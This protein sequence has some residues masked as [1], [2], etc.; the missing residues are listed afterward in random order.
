[1]I[2]YIFTF[3]LVF[4]VINGW[5]VE[6]SNHWAFKTV[7]RPIV[8][9]I[10]S[11]WPNDQIDRFVLSKLLK[12]GMQPAGRADRRTLIRRLSLDLAG[13]PPTPEQVRAFVDNSSSNAYREL[14]DQLLAS[15]RFGE[16]WARHWLDVARYADTK[17]YLAGNQARLFT[18]SYTYRD[19]VIDSFN[20]DLPYDRFLIEQLA[21]DKLDLADDNQPLAAMG[22]LTLG[23]RFLNNPHDIIDDRIDVVTRGLMALTVSCARCHD[24]K[25]DPIPAADYYSL[26]GVFASSHEPKE[27]PYISE[28]SDPIKRLSFQKELKR[29]QDN[30]N[31]YEKA[32]YERIRKQVK[33]Q[34][35]EYIWAAHSAAK[36]AAGEIDELARKSKL[37]PDVTR[38]WMNYLSERR[39]ANDLVFAAWFALAEIDKESYVAEFKGVLDKESL[40][41]VPLEILEV[42]GQALSLKDAAK[43]FGKLCFEADESQ[44]MLREVVYSN[45]SPAKLSDGDV[46]RIMEVSGKE[47]IRSR[48]RK[49]D[50]IE[51]EH[52]GAPNRAMVMID[53]PS[54]Y[55]PYVFLR[56]NPSSKG[57]SVP[58]Q[59]LSVLS[60]GKRKP[61]SNGSGRLEMA[62]AIAASDNPLTA[63]VMVNR[64]WMHLFGQGL[65]DT[66][67]DFGVRAELPSHPELLDYLASEFVSN[68]WSVKRL[69]RSILLSNTYQQGENMHSEYAVVDPSNRLLWQMNRRRLDFESMRDSI[70]A[71]SGNLNLRQRGRSEKIENKPNANRR[72]IYGF[73]D[74]QNLPSLFRTFDFAGPDTTC[75]RRFNTTIPQQSLYL[76][77]SPFIEAQAKHLVES[78]CVR[79]VVGEERIRVI[80]RQIYQRDPKELELES[81]K[82]FI[83]QFIPAAAAWQ[84]LGQALLVS[85][86]MMFVD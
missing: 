84:M 24:H 32:Q 55:N 25:Y 47:G 48:R 69:I 51:G 15:P 11:D 8:P 34:T 7:Q 60:D 44:L 63:R 53:K 29:R 70:L 74:R 28:S 49:F 43:A 40:K 19:Y 30:L 45:G 6:S 77:N 83:D 80:F 85:N 35:G 31:N 65:V 1:M 66:P 68:G 64:V 22:F 20:K 33:Q 79:L 41:K 50:E 52:P 14:V 81:A 39:K 9:K 76:L 26:Y 57:V 59:F 10:D 82:V 23:R 46:W 27:K 86:E 67:S 17:G 54:L 18:H 4:V 75:G 5:P 71:V 58:R 37:D 12:K 42:L 2:R 16:R 56:G 73:I 36:V 3:I 61:F 21:A 72:T 38:R 13:L 62:Q 78:D